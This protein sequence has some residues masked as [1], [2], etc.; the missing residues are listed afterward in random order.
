MS[1]LCG[2]FCGEHTGAGDPAVIATMAAAI[3]ICKKRA[4]WPMSI[5][6]S[7]GH[8]FPRLPGLMTGMPCAQSGQTSGL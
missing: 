3:T 2:W 4:L 5:M 8:V 6:S 7:V 1:G